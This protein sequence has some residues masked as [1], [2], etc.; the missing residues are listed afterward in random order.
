MTTRTHGC[1]NARRNNGWLFILAVSLTLAGGL[2]ARGALA[3]TNVVAGDGLYGIRIPVSWSAS[4]GA[5]SYEVWR[6]VTSNSSAAA[7]LA[8]TNATAYDDQNV[9]GGKLY[10]YWIKAI[11]GGV[12]SAVSESDSGWR[13]SRQSNYSGDYDGDG[14][15]D[16]CVYIEETGTW[17]VKLSTANYYT[18]TLANFLG[19]PGWLAVPSDYDFDGKCDPA[20]VMDGS[21]VWNVM[22]SSCNYAVTNYPHSYGGPGVTVTRGKFTISYD[23][24]S[25]SYDEA[26]KS[27]YFTYAYYKPITYA[28]YLGGQGWSPMFMNFNGAGPTCAAYERATGSWQVGLGSGGIATFTGLLGGPKYLANPG[29]YDGDGLTD[30][31]VYNPEDGHWIVKLSSANYLTVDL[32]DFLH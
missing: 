8:S 30:Y 18:I 21:N 17:K 3:P 10:Y 15:A 1:G 12:T 14:L 16:P 7:L 28:N 26:D 31:A 11:E 23:D 29:D 13:L 24:W 20:V 5:T 27:W 19:G 25:C 2:E 6:A 9:E 22:Y 32:P 4:T